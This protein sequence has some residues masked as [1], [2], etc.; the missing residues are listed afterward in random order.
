MPLI[1]ETDIVTLRKYVKM[2]FTSGAV[3]S[4]PDID[5][6]ERK[7]LVPILTQPVLTVLQTQVD[8]NAVTWT[9]L[10]NICRA[11]AAPLAVWL[12]LPFMQ[13]QLSDNG[14][15]SDEQAAHQWEFVKVESALVNKGMAALEDLIDHLIANASTYAWTNDDAKESFIRT[16]TEFSKYAYLHQPHLTFQQLK[17]L[18]REVEDH[19]IK[20]TIGDD[21]FA[22][23]RDKTDPSR[24][25]KLATLLIKKSVAQYTLVRA[26]ERLPVKIT[27]GGLMASIQSNSDSSN[28]ERP[29][30]GTAL[31]RLMK[32]AQREGDSYQVQLMQYLNKVASPTI[33]LTFFESEYYTAPATAVANENNFRVGICAL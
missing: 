16:G 19:F 20:A 17:P 4:M 14:L 27:P 28:P 6:A 12:D 22:Y 24:E 13:A 33:F 7:F 9:T 2:N 5:A 25:E 31:D 30:E 1:K 21:F 23:L 18:M 8:A 29:A 10:L 11:A 32:S 3:K 26:V 15:K